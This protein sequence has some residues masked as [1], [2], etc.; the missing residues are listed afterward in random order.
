MNSTLK[1]H[2]ATAVA[3]AFLIAWYYSL[4]HFGFFDFATNL[5]PIDYHGAGLMFGIGLG[6]APA[7]FLW[8]RFNRWV[9]KKLDIKGIYI[10]DSYY[11]EKTK[12]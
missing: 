3:F 11:D 7:F 9:E 4:Q 8:S 1:H 6:M 12:R 5:M 10:E 2:L